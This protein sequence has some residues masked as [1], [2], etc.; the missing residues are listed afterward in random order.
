MIIACGVKRIPQEPSGPERDKSRNTASP[1]TTGGRPMSAFSTTITASRPRK[2]VSAISAPN[3]TPIS[4]ANIA[5]ERLTASDSRTIAYSAG[6]P[7][8]TS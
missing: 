8:R 4:A 7:L 2:R 1:T 5:A 3:G 6:S